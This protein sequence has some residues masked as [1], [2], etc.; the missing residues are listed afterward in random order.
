MNSVSRFGDAETHRRRVLRYRAG[1][2]REEEDVIATEFALTLHVNGEEFAT[3]VCTPTY[4]E[5]LVCGFLASEGVIRSVD[6]IESVQVSLWTGTARVQTRSGVALHPAIYNKRYIG[7]CCGKG[8]QSFYFQSDALTARPV[9]D[10]VSLS[11]D[12][13]FRAMDLLD[14]SSGLFEETGGVHVAALVRDGQLVLARAD[15]GRHNALDKIYGHCLR[16][17]ES[18]SGTAIAF[19]GRIS[20]EVLLKVAKIGVGA[21][22]ARGAPTLLAIDLAEELNITAIGF[23]RGRSFNVYSHPWRMSDVA[24]E[25]ATERA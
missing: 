21:V 18:L 4:V 22:I 15:I 3:L 13:V 20:S 17:G 19:S 7:S 23:V 9:A 16:A 5:D 25:E 12:D 11:A 14:A 24:V 6:E 8:R 2:Y 10:A 1:A